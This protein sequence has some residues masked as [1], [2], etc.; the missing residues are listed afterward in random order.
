MLVWGAHAGD[1]SPK[2][3]DALPLTKTEFRCEL[4]SADQ[5]AALASGPLLSGVPA[6]ESQRSL[7]RDL[8]LDTPEGSLRRRGIVCRMRVGADGRSSMSLRIAGS[9]GSPPTRVSAATRSSEVAE[10]IASGN[11]VVHRLRGIVD[12]ELLQV[13]L[14][15][16]VDR[17]TRPVARDWLH[18]PRVA[19]H[20][21][22][23]S[24]RRGGKDGGAN[25]ASFFQMCAHRLRG[26]GSELDTLER[27]LEQEHGLRPST[28][29]THERAEL[30]VKWAR[31]EDVPRGAGYSDSVLRAAI[32]RDGDPAP[33]FINPELS[34]LAFQHRVL[35]LAEDPATPVRE[36]LRFLSIVS[37]NVDEFFMVRFAR[38]A[39]FGDTAPPEEPSDDGLMPAEQLAAITESVAAIALR[40]SRCLRDCY[41]V[42]AERG[43]RIRA[44]SDLTDTQREMLRGRFRTEIQPLLT[45]FAMTLSPGHPLPRLS[46]LSLSLAIVL[47]NRGGGPPRFAELELPA[48]VPRFFNV[49]EGQGHDYVAL[50]DVV[51]GNL[52]A[53]YP[54]DV[55]VEQS[56]VF[57]VTR[58]AELALD[59]AGA[60]DLLD[61]VERATAARGQGMVVRLEVERGM[62]P[63][64]RALLLEDVR[65]EHLGMDAPCLVSDVDEIEGLID[66]RGLMELELPVD[67]RASYP[68]LDSRRPFADAGGTGSAFDAV[69]SGDVLVHHPFDSFTDTVVRFLHEAARDPAVVAI[70]ITLYRVGNP[71]PVA[72]A[73]LEAARQGKAVT[74][75]VELKARFDEEINVGW[76][77]ALEAAGGHVVR[78]LVGFKNHA[79]VALVIRRENAGLRR[80]V[81]IGTGNYNARSGE[82]Y[83]DLSFF[84]TDDAITSD[85][86]DLFNELTGM[87]EPPRRRSRALLVAPH[88]LLPAV[89]EHIDREAAHA[90]AGREARITA[91]FNGLSDPDVVRALYRASRDGVEIDLVVRG[92]CTLRPRVSGRSDRIRVESVVGRFLEHS[93]V[94]R[95]ANG[96]DPRYFIGSADLRPR[97]LRRRVELLVPIVNPAHRRLLDDILRLYA[98]DPTAWDLQPDGSYVARAGAGPSTQTT[99]ARL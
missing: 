6:D 61:E 95:F 67:P 23:V 16:Q 22:R 38:L 77:R 81:H 13:Q 99:L 48:S 92:I 42:L 88:H 19:V 94:Y 14:D 55:G 4:L 8:Y 31:L 66:L 78:G 39:V 89:L 33:E 69:G 15:L 73:L 3:A 58:T 79:K 17:L 26:D 10:A 53:I 93:R 76:A 40:E 57:R 30:A 32:D 60:D 90:R 52:E 12:P 82:Q 86:S 75:F 62:P 45:P 70:K 91:K 51:R 63:V 80:Y 29:A 98:A 46:H 11:A 72:D 27:A 7:H 71:S 83:T 54:T 34:L 47:R 85:V 20:L 35:S 59:E 25:A 68:R 50:E 84:T 41:D 28:V 24:V 36:R 21:D 2:R 1:G 56:Y 37:A 65:R 44:W 97:N 5:L 87:S 18:R 9:N 43:I 96:G 74:V 64:L 49:T